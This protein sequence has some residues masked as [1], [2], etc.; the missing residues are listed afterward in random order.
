MFS[1]VFSSPGFAQSKSAPGGPLRLESLEDRS[2]PTTITPT[3]FADGGLGSGSLRDAVLQ[4]NADTGTG[5]DTIQLEAGTYMLTIQNVGGRHETAGLTGD[6]NLTQTSHRWIIQGAGP[7]T[8]IDASQL[9]DRVFQIVNPGT[10][11]MFQDLIIQGGL[12]QDDGSEGTLPDT[13]DALGGGILNNGGDLTLNNVVL[14]NNA[15][16]GGRGIHQGGHRAQGGGFYTA[17]GSLTIANSEISNN[18]A[19]GGDG[20]GYPGGAS[21]GGGLYITGTSLTVTNSKMT[22]NQAVGGY[23]GSEG[24]GGALYASDSLLSVAN[25]TIA[26][27][28]VTGGTGGFGAQPGGSGG[29]GGA[30]KGGG[31][32]VSNGI[33]TVINSTIATNQAT[34]GGGGGG[35]PGSPCFDSW[36]ISAGAGGSGGASQGGG[37]YFGGGMLTLTNSTIAANTLRGGPGGPGGET[38]SGYLPGPGGGGGPS[39]GGALYFSGDMLA[40][41]NS[42][43][44]SNYATGGTHGNGLGGSDGPASGGG[45]MNQGLLQTRDTLVA[46]NTVDGPGTN[47][48]PD[49]AGDLGSLGHN[50]VGHSQGGSGFEA[51][52][53]LDVDPLLGPLQDNGGPTQTIALLPGSPAIDA[54]DNTDA[55]LWDQRGPGFPRIVNSIIDIGAF[56]VQAHAH[57]RPSGQPLAD[58]LPVAVV[59]PPAPN[60]LG[61]VVSSPGGLPLSPA[62][63]FEATHRVP[64]L[65][66]PLGARTAPVTPCLP[67]TPWLRPTCGNNQDRAGGGSLGDALPDEVDPLP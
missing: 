44:A 14:H 19:V 12:A 53:L 38:G 39:Q 15:A 49:L 23:G 8:I 62:A 65:E 48:G 9:Q 37:L 59:R 55:P 29:D 17:G 56:E 5:D 52:D 31:L 30:S 28:Q 66:V 61:P 27:N 18:L 26:A 60:A 2:V 34:G 51:T 41:A 33:L 32:Y 16:R 36:C 45:M 3:T 57:G 1:A 7:S 63:G 21:Q 13:T 35:A 46:G 24:A 43:I 10:Q 58:P 47:S 6:L 50:L 25:S 54:G 67:L 22:G 11:V 42:T 4:L 40:V 64:T 20:G